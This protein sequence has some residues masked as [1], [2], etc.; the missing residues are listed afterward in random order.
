M[1][2]IIKEFSNR[3]EYKVLRKYIDIKEVSVE[4]LT[5]G[6]LIVPGIVLLKMNLLQIKKLNTWL[7]N[8]SN[9]LILLPNWMEVD[10]SKIFDTS[11]K[12]QIEKKNT[13]YAGDINC[14]YLVNGKFQDV[15]FYNDS[16]NLGV[17]YRNN[18]SSGII[19]IITLPLLDYKLS[20]N[21]DVFRDMLF[22]CFIKATD[23]LSIDIQEN[24]EFVLGREHEYVLIFL[25][26]GYG[27]K[28]ENS[29]LVKQYFGVEVSENQF[30]KIVKDL[31]EDEYIIEQNISDKGRELISN[32]KL[33]A[34]VKFLRGRKEKDEWN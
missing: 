30:E 11:I 31:R 28:K 24:D 16:G 18:T 26:S 3:T 32:K 1:V 12:I 5:K 34:F 21:H 23:S 20:M 19:T 27:L 17:N 22:N 15:F 4:E 10:L 2:Q 13:V 7:E 29:K 9:Q 25:D 33:R 14:N 8:S 6:I